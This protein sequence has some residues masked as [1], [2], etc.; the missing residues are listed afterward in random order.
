MEI[1]KY[2]FET[3]QVPTG[4]TERIRM[5]RFQIFKNESE[6]LQILFDIFGNFVGTDFF[7]SFH[8]FS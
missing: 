2:L 8:R 7:T 1:W 4:C 5:K 6:R 3:V